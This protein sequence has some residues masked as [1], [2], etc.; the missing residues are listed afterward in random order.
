MKKSTLSVFSLVCGITATALSAFVL[1]IALVAKSES[2]MMLLGF[3][4]VSSIVAGLVGAI[5]SIVKLIITKNEIVQDQED[6]IIAKKGFWFSAIPAIVLIF[7]MMI[8]ST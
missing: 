4:T 7:I 2:S 8:G 6:R 5:F 3:V 1:P